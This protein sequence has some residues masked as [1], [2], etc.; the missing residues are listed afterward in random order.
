MGVTR[1]N[2]PVGVRLPTIILAAR[3]PPGMSGLV[4]YSSYG[5]TGSLIAET[6][7]ERGLEPTLA[8][9]E[10]RT[11]ESQAGRC[12]FEVAGLDESEGLDMLLEDATAVLHCAGP[13]SRT[14]APMVEACVR[15]GTQYLDI[16]GGISVF[17]AIQSRDER[18]AGG[19]PAGRPRRCWNTSTP[20]ARSAGTALTTAR[21]ALAGEVE[22]GFQTP[23]GVYGPDLIPDG[24][25]REDVL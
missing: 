14:W 15:T 24:V 22:P 11:L 13:F 6:A 18:A 8:G 12:E 17:E 16:T 20:A 9:R 19:A 7:V 1:F 2:F 23:A 10:R 25:E 21:R 3:E 5:Y 4:I